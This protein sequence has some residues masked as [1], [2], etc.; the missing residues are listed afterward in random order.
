M[1]AAMTWLEPSRDVTLPRELA[2]TQLS[3]GQPLYCVWSGRRLDPQS[4]DIDHCIPWSAWACSDLWNLLPAHRAVNQRQKRD[5]LPSDERLRSAR[6]AIL[7]WWNGAYLRDNGA[8]L[9][10]RFLNEASASLPG[11][12]SAE[13]IGPGDVFDGMRLQQLRLRADQRVPEWSI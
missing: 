13:V 2:L 12:A 3:A 4:I 11:L 1:A 8:P 5:R 9:S 6:E 7:A 10:R